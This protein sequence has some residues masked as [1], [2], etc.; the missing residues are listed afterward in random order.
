MVVTREILFYTEYT[1]D[2]FYFILSLCMKPSIS[3]WAYAGNSQNYTEY[4]QEVSIFILST[5]TFRGHKTKFFFG[6]ILS[7]RR[8]PPFSHWV[9][10]GCHLFHTEYTEDIAFFILSI[11]RKTPYLYSVWN[12]QT[13]IILCQV[14]SI[15]CMKKTMSSVYSVCKRRR[16]AYTQYE[17]GDF[18]RILSIRMTNL[19]HTLLAQSKK[20]QSQAGL[21]TIYIQSRAKSWKSKSSEILCQCTFNEDPDPGFYLNADPDSGLWVLKT[22]INWKCW[23]KILIF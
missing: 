6:T 13:S 7:I 16:P 23:K 5:Y 20:F 1:Q 14:Q 22:Q 12:E 21:L 15:L 19:A 11:R 4:A 9:Y 2:V 8:N 3:Y 18:L 10:A 17:N